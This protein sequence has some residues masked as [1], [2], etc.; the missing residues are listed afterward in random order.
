MAIMQVTVM[1]L[2]TKTTSVGQYVAEFQKF[3]TRENIPHTLTDM[4]TII[5]GDVKE[6]L[7]V[8]AQIHELPF[9]KDAKRVVTHIVVDDRRD[10]KIAIGDKVASVKARLK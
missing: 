7:D 5:A 6:L 1:P 3:L 4:G 8:A 10:K 9:Q 2:G